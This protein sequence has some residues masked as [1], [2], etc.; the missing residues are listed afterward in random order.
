MKII[1][2]TTWDIGQQD[3]NRTVQ[4]CPRCGRHGL[5]ANYSNGDSAYAHRV[6]ITMVREA[7][8]HCYVK[9]VRS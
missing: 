7:V 2:Y 5:K 1:D 9:A 3:S 8:D 6:Q 4:V